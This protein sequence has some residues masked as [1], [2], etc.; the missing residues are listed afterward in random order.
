MS[1]SVKVDLGEGVLLDDA[2]LTRLRRD[3]KNSAARF[4]RGL[5]KVL[6]TADELEN[7]SLF[8]RRSNAHKD[9]AQKEALDPRRVNAILNTLTNT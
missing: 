7:K 8:G 4:A 9:A 1:R 2:T 6:F 5:L 3:A